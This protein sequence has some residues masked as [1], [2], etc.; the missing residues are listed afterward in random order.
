MRTVR[1]P[2]D[3]GKK[4]AE[5]R[6]LCAAQAPVR[7]PRLIQ[8]PWASHSSLTLSISRS[9]NAEFLRD[10]CPLTADRFVPTIPSWYAF[11]TCCS[12]KVT[13]SCP[14]LFASTWT[15]QSMEFSRDEY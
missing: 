3:Q 5:R 7:T 9:G 13:P 1:C 12:V 2:G 14:H 10:L 6:V 4:P 11:P 8:A 15:I